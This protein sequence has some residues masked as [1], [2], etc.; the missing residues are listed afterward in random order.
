MKL[1]EFM[2]NQLNGGITKMDGGAIFGVV[3]KP[4]WSK[5]YSVNNNNQVPLVTYPILIQTG[6]KN[7]IIDAGLGNAKLTKNKLKIMVLIMK[8]ILKRLYRSF[9]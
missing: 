7:I 5:K 4:L 3:P 2:I 1:G 8:A 9:I 6:E